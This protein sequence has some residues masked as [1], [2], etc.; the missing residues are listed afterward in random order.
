MQVMPRAGKLEGRLGPGQAVSRASCDEGR[1][2][3][4]QAVPRAGRAEGRPHCTM[5]KLAV[6][7]KNVYQIET[8]ILF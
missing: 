5:Y 4:G 1:L 6:G 3:Q 7:F 2:R 8:I